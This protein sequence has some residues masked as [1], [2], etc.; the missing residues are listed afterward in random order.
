[1]LLCFLRSVNLKFTLGSKN[2]SW[3]DPLYASFETSYC[4]GTIA[5]V[6]DKKH[7][8][9]S[10]QLTE[11]Y[12]KMLHRLQIM[13]FVDFLHCSSFVSVLLQQM[14]TFLSL[15]YIGAKVQR[16]SECHSNILSH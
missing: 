5:H 14:C 6:F 13:W 12:L 1:M 10:F 8:K 2:N 4:K 11:P 7:T 16:L 3:T 15:M 9:V